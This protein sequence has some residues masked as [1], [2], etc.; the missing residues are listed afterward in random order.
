MMN[1]IYRLRLDHYMD[2]GENKHQLEEP[3]VVSMVMDRRFAPAPVC[4]NRMMDMMREQ[5]LKMAEET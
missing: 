5:M 3:I 2:D 4:L 1:E